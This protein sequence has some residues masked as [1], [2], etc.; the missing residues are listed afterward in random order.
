[1]RVLESSLG[2]CWEVVFGK[3]RCGAWQF[4]AEDAFLVRG[5]HFRDNGVSKVRTSYSRRI[6]CT[7]LLE[8][9]V[10]IDITE[11]VK[12]AVAGQV[13]KWVGHAHA[14][15]LSHLYVPCLLADPAERK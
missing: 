7:R 5:C 1:M 8:D 14:R 2:I 15:E 6:S 11:G 12:L 13:Q 4:T 3:E 9:N 10:G